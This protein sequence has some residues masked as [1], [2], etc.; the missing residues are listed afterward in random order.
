MDKSELTI[1]TWSKGIARDLVNNLWEQT[2]GSGTIAM[3]LV[4]CITSI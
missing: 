2:V 3:F 4:S 1:V